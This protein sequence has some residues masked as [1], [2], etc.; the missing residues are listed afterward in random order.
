[1]RQQEVGPGDPVR[2][3]DWLGRSRVP[4]A[5]TTSGRLGW[6]GPEA[7]RCRAEP[8]FEFDQP[9]LTHHWFVQFV[10]PP[11]AMDLRY[12][13]V[14]WHVP[15]PAGAISLVPAGVPRVSGGYTLDGPHEDPK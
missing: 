11:E 9:A 6:A 13:G 15:L 8:A 14:K 12:E 3:L 4:G 10:R 5:Q 1:M 2:P 7:V